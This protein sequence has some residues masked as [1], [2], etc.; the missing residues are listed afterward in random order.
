MLCLVDN[1]EH[2]DLESLHKYLRKLKV[3]QETY[4]TQYHARKDKLTGEPIV[5]KNVDQYLNSEFNSKDNLKKWLNQDLVG[6][7]EWAIAWLK[8]RKEE[9]NL[10]YPPMQ[11]ELRSLV[12]PTMH[13]YNHVGRYHEICDELGYKV[14]TNGTLELHALPRDA[15][16]IIDTREQHPLKF[17]VPTESNKLN[18]GDYGLDYAHDNGIYIERKS[19]GDFVGTLSA[20]ETNKGDSN[21]M[22]F[23]R[24]LERAKELGHYVIMV[25]EEN[26]DTA[27]NGGGIS[28]GR[29]SS[30]HIF[31]NLRRLLHEFNNFQTLFV[32]NRAQA[33]KAIEVI[34]AAGESVKNVDLQYL[35]ESKILILE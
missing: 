35:F 7:R 19:L 2:P 24:E 9:K 23:I 31:Y 14:R 33:A 13:Y 27:L 16:I 34:L 26:L 18:C 20:R 4:Y 12:C 32:N 30:E 8:K 21:F 11:V 3:K 6:G 5:F 28:Y 29:V 10:V 15:K 25:V 17:S 1:T 22:R